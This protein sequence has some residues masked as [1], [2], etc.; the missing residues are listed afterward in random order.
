MTTTLKVQLTIKLDGADANEILDV[1]TEAA[2][3][4]DLDQAILNL[5]RAHLAPWKPAL[6]WRVVSAAVSDSEA[7]L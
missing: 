6:D 4:G 7:Q 1:L 3:D 5:V 2:I